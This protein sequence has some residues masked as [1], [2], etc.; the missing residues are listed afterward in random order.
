MTI[1]PDLMLDFANMWLPL[2]IYLIVFAA[3]V[4][5]LPGPRRDWLFTD[6]KQEI[7]GWKRVALSIGQLLTVAFI[8]LLVLTPIPMDLHWMTVFG[9]LLYLA[10]L[11]IVPVSIH[12]FGIAPEDQPM[13]EGPYRYS[14]NPQWVG[15][16]M[17]L[18]GLAVATKSILFMLMVL[19][20]GCIYHL[21][22]LAEEK[23]CLEIFGSSYEAYLE[24]VPRYLF[25]RN[26][27]EQ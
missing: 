7:H 1:L 22:I 10:G 6:P 14:R 15:L 19:F 8:M 24:K 11:I 18:L 25:I 5:R 4:V 13:I 12:F 2:A 20:I 3:A 9:V 27:M 17:V 21:Q 26:Q 23:L 16:F